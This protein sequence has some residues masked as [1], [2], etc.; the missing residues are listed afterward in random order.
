MKKS[1]RAP[2]LAAGKGCTQPSSP[3]TPVRKATVGQGTASSAG[4]GAAAPQPS[5]DVCPVVG[6]GASAGGLEAFSE[7]L[8]HLPV[9][10]P[11]ALVFVQHLD[12]KHPSILTDIL[13]RV[14]PIPVVEVKHGMRV[15]PG[16]VYVMPPNTR[17]T[18]VEGV[19]NLAPRSADRGPHMPIDHFLRSL[20]ED[21]GS[22]AIAII[23]SGSAS[24][25]ALG[26]KAVKAEG[27]ITFAE[28]PQLAKFDSMPRSAVASGAVDFVLPPKAIAQELIRIGRHPYLGETRAAPSPEAPASGPDAFDEILRK[29]REKSGID[30][31]L[32]R[33]TTIRRRIARRMMIHGLDT[34]EGYLGYLEA[35]PSQ[36]HALY[37]DLLVNVT[38][39]FRDPEAFRVLQRSVFPRILKQRPADAPIRV[40]A[41][42]CSTGEEAYSLAIVL[43]ES[44]GDADGIVPIQL[45]GS[46]VSETAVVKARAGIY[47]DNIELDVAGARLRRFFVKV[48]GQHQVRKAVRELCVFARHNLATDP[49]FSKMDL[50][51]CRNVLIYL[52][53]ELQKRVLSIFHYALKDPGF[54]MLGV[55]ETV[56]PL[57][58]FFSIVDKKYRVYAKKPTSRRFDLGLISLE[59]RLEKIGRTARRT[60]EAGG[61]PLDLLQEVDRILLS[62]YAPA[63]VLVN[64]A[65]EILQFRGHT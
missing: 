47:P 34:L 26:L 27:G 19:L 5:R 49:P 55:A 14:T 65:T 52:E 44:L 35:H 16:H 60:G 6:I 51:V 31:M 25:G 33:Q 39:F 4:R 9:D 46:D 22:R 61:G 41:P 18:I 13:S 20:S 43:L 8:S 64:E 37:N 38:R 59:Q 50:I 30:F 32:Y 2:R 10:A 56:G 62:K 3:L 28:A 53:P 45:F 57:A 15:E 29:L 21:Q 40:W 63:G 17:M 7:L 11:L 12:P 48:D 23:L 42:G 58:D 36:V 24:D 54:L 1:P